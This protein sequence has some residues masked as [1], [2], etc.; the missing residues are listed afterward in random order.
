[1]LPTWS[2]DGRSLYFG[3]DRSGRWELWKQPA[4]GGQATQLTWRGGLNAF[5]S[6]EG[7]IYY[8][9]GP[10]VA[11]IWR[12]PGEELVL[13]SVSAPRWG[14][15]MGKKGIYYV[16]AVDADQPAEIRY[17]DL[18]T[19]TSRL[20]GMTTAK[21]ALGGTCLTVSPDEQW[22]AWAQVDRAG[23]DIILVEG[24]R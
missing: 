14:W 11:G 16:E 13:D 8:S 23:S 22:V 2:R 18:A 6:G 4:S 20:I 5:E 3:S 24:F 12:L 1:M 7:Q 19:K 9:K 17:F 21:P 15:Y 10:S